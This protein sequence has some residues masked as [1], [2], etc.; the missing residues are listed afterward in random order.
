MNRKG[1]LETDSYLFAGQKLTRLI[2]ECDLL[3]EAQLEEDVALL[4]APG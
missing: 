3:L 4:N 2:K 1:K